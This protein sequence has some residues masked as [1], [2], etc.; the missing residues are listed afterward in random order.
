MKSRGAS[1]R[2]ASAASAAD[3]RVLAAL[4]AGVVAGALAAMLTR[5]PIPLSPMDPCAACAALGG[6]PQAANVGVGIGAIGHEM[7]PH[8]VTPYT[9]R[10]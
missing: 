5:R 10:L 6:C 9:F 1:G 3:V 2:G 4:L 7:S 8:E